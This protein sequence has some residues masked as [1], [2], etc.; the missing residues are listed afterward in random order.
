MTNIK[1]T[2]KT[3]SQ[4]SDTQKN[5]NK[6]NSDMKKSV[7][8]RNSTENKAVTEE[9]FEESK[10]ECEILFGEIEN[11]MFNEFAKAGEYTHE[12]EPEPENEKAFKVYS[13]QYS[14]RQEKKEWK[15][16]EMEIPKVEIPQFKIPP[17]IKRSCKQAL[18]FAAMIVVIVGVGVGFS[19]LSNQNSD[20]N[21]TQD[22]GNNSGY[23]F[24]LEEENDYQKKEETKDIRIT[25]TSSVKNM[26]KNINEQ[27]DTVNTTSRF[28]TL[29]DLIL[30]INSEQ[31]VILSK[32]KTLV[33]QFAG[34]L[35][36]K[37]QFLSEMQ[38][39]MDLLDDINRLLLVNKELF[40]KNG[41]EETY[42]ILTDNME[43]I[44]IYG[45]K[46]VY[47]VQQQQESVIENIT[48]G[49]NS[50]VSTDM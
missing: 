49:V 12:K 27:A 42:N 39:Q 4:A 35:I 14:A 37:K 46:E 22:K 5:E 43:T 19:K 20:N 44:I 41:E 18:S 40:N 26:S 24:S 47:K 9:I 7:P 45:S 21:I 50:L 31:G 16:P 17:L 38:E 23:S 30:Y 3:E 10:E 13:D 1:T 6:I 36:S 8:E 33:T 25:Q 28:Q 34:G 29:D 48:E 2:K 15:M 11:N 32:E